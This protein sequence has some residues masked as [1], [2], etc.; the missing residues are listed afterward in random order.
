MMWKRFRPLPFIFANDNY[1]LR[2]IPAAMYLFSQFHYN[3]VNCIRVSALCDQFVAE[4]KQGIEDI[5]PFLC[6]EA[7]GILSFSHMKITSVL[8]VSITADRRLFILPTHSIWLS[9]FTFSVIPSRSARCFIRRSNISCACLS[10][11]AR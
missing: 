4:S 8:T 9:A 6:C 3:L 7:K 10:M 5:P 1:T 2:K 11:S